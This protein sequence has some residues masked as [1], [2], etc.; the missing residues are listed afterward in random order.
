MQVVDADQARAKMIS[1]NIQATSIVRQV[2]TVQV[3]CREMRWGLS[4]AATGTSAAESNRVYEYLP[5][6]GSVY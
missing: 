6:P 2:A 3:I 1:R 5:A 4:G